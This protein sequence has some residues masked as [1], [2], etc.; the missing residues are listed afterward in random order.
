M[1]L[2][3][4]LVLQSSIVGGRRRSWCSATP[5]APSASSPT[6]FTPS[7][8]RAS[9]VMGLVGLRASR[10]PPDDD[11][12]YGHRKYETL[13]AAGIFVFLL[14][15]GDRSRAGRARPAAR[16]R[17]RARGHVGQLRGDGRDAR[18]S[19]CW[20]CATSGRGTHAEERAAAGRRGAHAQRRAHVV[21]ACSSSLA[22]VRARLPAARSDRRARD[23]GV[24]RAH[25]DRRSRA[26]RRAS[27]RTA[28]C[29]DE[30]DI[31]RVVM[32]VPEVLGLPSHPHARLARTT[33]SSTCTSGSRG[34]TPLFDAHRLSH[35][36][37]DRLMAQFP[38]D[39][40]RDHSHRTAAAGRLDSRYCDQ[41]LAGV[42]PARSRGRRL[43]RSTQTARPAHLVSRRVRSA[44]LAW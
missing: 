18:R 10:K 7:P 23:R 19:T 21:R 15:V 13:A 41:Q 3:R 29:I 42:T 20:S 26:T 25:R 22:G 9:N 27:C 44:A 8:T 40:R 31:R 34:D 12:P 11:H 1:L 28:S 43:D 35:V 16:R 38:A 32:G 37:K 36:V 14:L 2:T 24:H 17:R 33:S 6:A 5:P 4:V 39:R 30:D